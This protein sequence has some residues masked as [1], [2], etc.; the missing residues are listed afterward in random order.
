MQFVTHGSAH[1]FWNFEGS[2]LEAILGAITR[3]GSI[4]LIEEVYIFDVN[5]PGRN[6]DDWSFAV[7]D[8][9]SRVMSMVQR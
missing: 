2:G 3:R 6:P 1:R 4:D 7:T 5:F 9:R 8:V